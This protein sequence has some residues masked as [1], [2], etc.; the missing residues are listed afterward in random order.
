MRLGHH[1]LRWR[2]PVGPRRP[3]QEVLADHTCRAGQD[4]HPDPPRR[5]RPGRACR[6]GVH[7]LP[8]SERPR[9]RD[10]AGR[11]PPRA[12]R[13]PRACPYSGPVPPR[14]GV[15]CG[16]AGGVAKSPRF[17]PSCTGT[18]RGRR[19]LATKGLTAVCTASFMVSLSDHSSR[20]RPSTRS[21]WCCGRT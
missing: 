11:L 15:V 1:P 10:R 21:G 19:P 12:P 6:A 4:T 3:L 9:L 7:V 2:R 20:S 18:P 16:P 5:E 8:G 14:G 13:V 17:R